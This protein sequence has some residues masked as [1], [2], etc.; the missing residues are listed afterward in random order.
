MRR[1]I[2]RKIKLILKPIIFVVIFVLIFSYLSNLFCRKTLNGTWNHT[3]KISGFYNEPENEFDVVFFGSSNTYCSF[4]PLVLYEE[5]GIKSYVFASQQQ[6]V[7]ASYAYIKEALKT[8]TPKLIVLD[9][10]MLSKS[11]EYYDDGVNYSFMDDIPLSKNK[12]ELAFASAPKEERLGLIFNFIKYH[13]RLFELTEE[14]YTFDRSKTR[15]YLKGYVLLEDT[16]SDAKKYDIESVEEEKLPA[17]KQMLY[18]EK[19]VAL[20]KEK[21]IPLLLVKTPSNA[22]LEEQKLFNFIEKFANENDIEFINYNLF[23]P[24]IGLVMEEDFYDKSHLNY[25]GAQKFTRFFADYLKEKIVASEDENLTNE[26]WEEDLKKYYEY[27]ENIGK[28]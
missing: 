1:I 18:L 20:A 14:D 16:F 4:N 25:K 10:L 8:Q 24:Q 2:V 11:E 21:D 5:T 23:Y 22:T 6:P 3:Q 17:D 7:W 26:S 9:V 27:C 12:I 28:E 19:I 13:S 15:D